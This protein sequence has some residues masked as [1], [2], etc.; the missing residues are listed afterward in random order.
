M[1]GPGG[2]NQTWDFS[3]LTI[4]NTDTL[5]FTN[6]NWLGSSAYFPGT[7]LGIYMG[8][9]NGSAYLQNTSGF[10]TVLGQAGDFFGNGDT[11]AMEFKPTGE[12]IMVWPSTY[13]TSFNDS[14]VLDETFDGSMFG[15]DSVRV[16][17]TILKNVV[18]DAWGS[19]I[20]PLDTFN[21][22]RVFHWAESTD[23]AWIYSAMGGGW[24][25]IDNSVDTSYT[26][27]WWTNDANIGF[28]LVEMDYDPATSSV[29][30]ISWL[31]SVPVQT[32]SI[33][34]YVAENI[35]IFPNPAQELV[36]VQLNPIHYH[37]IEVIDITGRLIFSTPVID[38]VTRIDLKNNSTGTYIVRAIGTKNQITR[39]ITLK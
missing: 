8:T 21:T 12:K 30:G 3:S 31:S 32:A 16:K 5:K 13:N 19:L 28:P 39:K 25:L 2:A 1:P 10:L 37:T 20:T 35:N 22:L 38:H 24:M 9:M 15:A 6:P 26:Y 29:L 18:V 17:S 11:V 14:I 27:N 4:D 33:N 7:N 36:N 34:S 23:S